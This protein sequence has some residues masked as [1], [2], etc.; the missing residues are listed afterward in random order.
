MYIYNMFYQGAKVHEI[1]RITHKRI[2][3]C[4]PQLRIVSLSFTMPFLQDTNISDFILFGFT[5]N[6]HYLC[7]FQESFMGTI[8]EIWRHCLQTIFRY[9]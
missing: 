3:I 8:D 2:K 4:I 1:S 5:L 7:V 9:L 6:L